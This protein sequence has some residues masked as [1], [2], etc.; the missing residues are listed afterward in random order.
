[1]H[2]TSAGAGS[3]ALHLAAYGGRDDGLF[4][5]VMSDS[6]FIPAEPPVAEL[7]AQFAAT[8]NATGCG[9]DNDDDY[10]DVADVMACLRG[11]DVATLQ[12]AGNVRRPFAT[13]THKPIFYWTPTVDGEFIRDGPHRM[14]RRGEFVRMPVLLGTDTDGECPV[15]SGRQSVDS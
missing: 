9:D 2:G 3:V 15:D 7:E 12:T 11:L 8:L 4:V 6:I 1:M 14:F 13:R 10:D 5:G